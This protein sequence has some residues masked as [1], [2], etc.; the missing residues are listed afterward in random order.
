MTGPR[1]SDRVFFEA[2]NL[3]APALGKVKEAVDGG[4]WTAARQAMATHIR[5]RERPVWYANW[6]ERDDG[7]PRVAEL[8]K[9]G[10]DAVQNVAMTV[11]DGAVRNVLMEQDFGDEINWELNPIDYREWTW[12]L[13]RH[14]FWPILGQA[15]W[16]TGDERYAEAFVR[17]MTHWVENVLAPVGE[18]GNSWKDDAE[19][20]TDRTNCWRTIE[21][22]IRMGQTWPNAF[23]YLLP[24]SAFSADA[25]CLMLKSM[26]EHARHLMQWPRQGGNWL[27]MESNGM[28]H[29]G[30]LFPEFKE[31]EAWRKVAMERLYRELDAQVYPDGAQIEL[32][33]NY[34]QVS[35]IN[36]AMA[37]NMARLNDR[38]IP[39]DYVDKLERMYHYDLYMAMPDLRLP[40]LNDGGRT[41]IRPFMEQGFRYFPNRADFRWAATE[42]A[43][44][45]QPETLSCV[46]PYAGHFVMRSGWRED[47]A[48]LFFDGGPFG[49]GHQHE[50]KLNIVVYTH[51]RTHIADPGSYHY[52]SSPWRKYVIST[53]AHNTVMVDGMEQNQRGKPR[54]QY[55]VSEPLPH[56][57]ISEV[58]YDY[59]SASY[60]EGYGPERD[61]TVTHTR[62]IL[63]VKPD[64]W[65]VAD[66]LA[67]SDE[68]SHTYEAMFH[69]DAEGAE[70]LGNGQSVE[71]RNTE[72]GNFGIYGAVPYGT[73]MEIVSGQEEPEVQGWIPGGRHSCRPIPTPVFQAEGSG[74]V[75]MAYV[76]CPIP[77]GG[78]SPISHVERLLGAAGELASVG[79]RVVLLD[80]REIYFGLREAG[81]GRMHSDE[82]DSDAEAAA[83]VIA[84]SG[85]VGDIILIKGTEVRVRGKKLQVGQYVS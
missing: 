25:I 12:G 41:D 74:K 84:P 81:D 16:K 3:D 17:Q 82:G 52:D 1:L 34:H 73:Q 56:T 33:S 57:W 14:R 79:G 13:S 77:T 46:F 76:L 50:D 63:F 5:G 61:T 45:R 18:D 36:F 43:E 24:S 75:A 54:D 20:G 37:F 85:K 72:G 70:V 65:I 9:G 28:Y 59:A 27:A 39:E 78:P 66:F 19:M 60:C 47:D 80:G 2:L 40:P 42:R 44:G 51:G 58:D 23:F 4:N 71:T 8:V 32:T 69:L 49:Y 62:S 11:A 10:G 55:V 64:L 15:Y 31:A 30:V 38:G 83:V 35:L 22:G 53:R 6:R 26:V 7:E 29:V 48:Y 67:P 68:V 21:C